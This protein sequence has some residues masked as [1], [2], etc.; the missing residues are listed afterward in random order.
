MNKVM[1]LFI[2]VFLCGCVGKYPYPCVVESNLHN[3][4]KSPTEWCIVPLQK[5]KE[6]RI[7]QERINALTESIDMYLT[8]K[9]FNT[10]ILEQPYDDFDKEILSNEYKDCVVII[11]KIMFWMAELRDNVAG[12]HGVRE[13]AVGFWS[14]ISFGNT[15][16]YYNGMVPAASLYIEIYNDGKQY[17]E[18][19]GGIE[20]TG[21]IRRWNLSTMP[22]EDFLEDDQEFQNAMDI[23]FEQLLE[24]IE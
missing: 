2:I 9:G 20:L 14:S 8:K 22:K 7:S 21:K 18:N 23:A 17:Y 24:S 12:W 13:Y 6:F 10:R 19:A 1:I 11:P 3:I 15:A 16:T 4:D 5:D